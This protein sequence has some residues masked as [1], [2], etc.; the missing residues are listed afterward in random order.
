MTLGL[1]ILRGWGWKKGWRVDC[2]WSDRTCL[3][4]RRRNENVWRSRIDMRMVYHVG[5]VNSLCNMGKLLELRDGKG[6]TPVSENRFQYP[7]KGTSEL[8]PPSIANSRNFDK[9]STILIK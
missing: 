6:Q 3:V 5:G 9:T 1:V 8:G 2:H 7:I 4:L